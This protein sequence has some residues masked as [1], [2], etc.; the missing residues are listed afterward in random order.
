MVDQDLQD[1]GFP[2]GD[3]ATLTPHDR[4]RRQ[5]R[6]RRLVG[7][8]RELDRTERAAAAS[9]KSLATESIRLSAAAAR[10]ELAAPRVGA[11]IAPA[12]KV[13][14]PAVGGEGALKPLGEILAIIAPH[15]LVAN[16]V[17]EL[18]DARLQRGAAFRGS[19][20]ATFELARPDHVGE[21]TCRCDHFLD[22]A[23]AAGAREIVGVLPF[24]Q[25]RKAQAF[26]RCEERQ[27]KVRCTI[28]RLLT[29]LVAVE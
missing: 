24:R 25:Q 29:C 20:I 3:G 19:K 8:G 21:R 2:A 7:A 1:Q 13:A 27:S 18:L 26:S 14:A 17:G 16:A 12:G 9:T 28:G 23:T 4:A 15:H 6:A 5:L 22:G 11:E 10:L